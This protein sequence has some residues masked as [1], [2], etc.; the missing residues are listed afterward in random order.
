M[1]AE[2][3]KIEPAA[4]GTHHDRLRDPVLRRLLP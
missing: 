1:Q 2:T 4:A 3:R